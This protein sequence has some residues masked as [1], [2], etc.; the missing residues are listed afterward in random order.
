M[1]FYYCFKIQIMEEGTKPPPDLS[2][3]RELYARCIAGCATTFW[4]NLIVHQ[5]LADNDEVHQ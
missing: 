2:P 5:L 1:K 4:L 3:R